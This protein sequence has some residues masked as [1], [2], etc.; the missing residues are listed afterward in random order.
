MIRVL[1]TGSSGD[2]GFELCRQFQ[3]NGHWVSGVDIAHRRGPIR[4]QRA[5][6]TAPGTM[7]RAIGL[8]DPDLI[9][10]AAPDP[11]APD[12]T[13]VA[14]MHRVMVICVVRTMTHVLETHRVL[15]HR[16]EQPYSPIKTAMAVRLL[17]ERRITPRTAV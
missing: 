4:S 2:L 6:I 8:F 11:T 3:A 7:I 16:P 9:V 1:I 14:R 15:L 17:G 12:V 5:D 13:A 10:H